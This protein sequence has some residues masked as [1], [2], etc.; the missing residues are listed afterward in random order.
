[1]S[2]VLGL[3]VHAL[4]NFQRKTARR[5][6]IEQPQ[7]G[8]LAFVQRFG[9]ALQLT[10]HFHVLLPEAVFEEVSGPEPSARVALLPGPDDEEVE[11]LLR[12]VALGVVKL[13]RKRGKLDEPAPRED[14][15]DF[16]RARATRQQRLPLEDERPHSKRRR[17]AF[18]DGFSAADTWVH[19]N[20]RGP[21]AFGQ[22]RRPRALSLERLSASRWA[23][24]L[25][26]APFGV[27]GDEPGIPPSTSFAALP[28]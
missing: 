26:D 24:R 6:G 19:E 21:R 7:V 11:T 10:P 8:A 23:A 15:L 9:S 14:A 12:A 1:M 27:G 18:L 2:E 4:F 16:L 25:P 3:F 28:R 20:N 13:L 17:C 5:L 22:L